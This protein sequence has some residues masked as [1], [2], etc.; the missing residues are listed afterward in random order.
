MKQIT[1]IEQCKRLYKG[2]LV[3]TL[4]D[5]TPCIFVSLFTATFSIVKTYPVLGFNKN[6][7]G[8][9]YP[10]D[11]NGY[12]SLKEAN[13]VIRALF[14]VKKYLYFKRSERK[15]LGSLE[16]EGVNIVCCKG[17]Y[18]STNGNEYYSFFNNEDDDVIAIWQ[19]K[20]LKV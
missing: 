6:F 13:R 11:E 10:C 9:N 12:C 20:G 7:S 16:L 8:E 4:F 2:N 5:D 17:H 14:D 19:L 15:K 1:P 3:D 18:I